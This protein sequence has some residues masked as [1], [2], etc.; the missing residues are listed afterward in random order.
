MGI[1]NRLLTLKGASENL[2]GVN[3][4]SITGATYPLSDI[5]DMVFVDTTSNL[6]ALTAP[7]PNVKARAV[8]IVKT[9]AG[10][11]G[12]TVAAYGAET[13]NG[14]A[15]PYT[16]PN[17]NTAAKGC[18]TL[19]SDGTNWTLTSTA[20]TAT[21]GG[22]TS[23]S[24]VAGGIIDPG[25]G[26][27]THAF[28]GFAYISG[29]PNVTGTFRISYTGLGASYIGAGVLTC[30]GGAANPDNPVYGFSHISNGVADIH[31][32]DLAGN[33]QQLNLVQVLIFAAPV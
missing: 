14:S 15:G 11:N 22:T 8:T 29:C 7:N 6:V 5:E 17:S 16:L 3:T 9:N 12:I 19:T 21:G 30:I 31:A 32:Y 2:G 23:G 27:V 25:T 13:F 28:G 10:A 24:C 33:P 18:W 20:N 26:T 1:D 4:T